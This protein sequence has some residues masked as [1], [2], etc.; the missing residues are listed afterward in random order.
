[1]TIVDLRGC[2]Y[3]VW[4]LRARRESSLSRRAIALAL[5]IVL[6]AI[7]R[8]A[9][10]QVLNE[11]E[12][13]AGYLFN[14]VKFIEWPSHSFPDGAS[15]LIIGVVGDDKFSE[16]IE[17]AINGKIANGRRLLVKRF[18]NFKA[19]TT[20][21]IVFVRAS[22]KE[23]IQQTLAAAGTALTVGESEGFAHRGGVI[24]FT[25]SSSKLQIEINQ[26]S[27]DRAG[28]KISAKLLSLARVIRN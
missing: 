22:E 23:R 16:T 7:F 28:L 20:C 24:N 11:Y 26:T 19:L 21:H 3:S 9:H 5:V 18:A 8:D 13:K 14:F 4:G 15:P 6:C 1:V 17:K 25:F 10:A 12:A 27:A 2:R